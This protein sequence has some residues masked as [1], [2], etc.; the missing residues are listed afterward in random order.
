L[1]ADKTSGANVTRVSYQ[2]QVGFGEFITPFFFF[3]SLSVVN[4]PVWAI[5]GDWRRVGQHWDLIG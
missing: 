5:H 4:E 3:A 2:E 1:I